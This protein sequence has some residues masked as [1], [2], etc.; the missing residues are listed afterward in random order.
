MTKYKQFIK[1]K[2]FTLEP[3]TIIDFKNL[4][5]IHFSTMLFLLGLSSMAKN[6][7]LLLLEYIGLLEFL[8][9]GSRDWKDKTS[10]PANLVDGEGSFCRWQPYTYPKMQR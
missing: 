6:K 3:Y 9:H 10:L 7:E 1:E 5:N 8:T 4:V 2:Y